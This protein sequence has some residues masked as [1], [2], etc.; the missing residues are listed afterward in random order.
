MMFQIKSRLPLNV[1]VVLQSDK[2]LKVAN[3]INTDIRHLK[4][5]FDVDIP[6]DQCKSLNHLV[7]DCGFIK[8]RN[9]SLKYQ[10]EVV[11]GLE[12]DK[13][14]RLSN[15]SGRITQA[16]QTY[17]LLD[18]HAQY[19]IAEKCLARGVR[20][21]HFS[22][23]FDD[24]CR[25]GIE[26]P[27]S[28]SSEASDFSGLSPPAISATFSIQQAT[29]LLLD[30][31]HAMARV[32]DVVPKKHPAA[33]EFCQ[34]LSQAI[35]HQNPEDVA[36]VKAA[37]SARSP[38][39]SYEA[40]L[41][42]NPNWISQRIR[43]TIPQ[44]DVLCARLVEVQET[45]SQPQFIVDDIKLLNDKVA[46]EF[47]K[48]LLHCRRG[49]LS[50][51][52]GIPLLF[53]VRTDSEGLA[54]YRHIRGNSRLESSHQKFNNVFHG[55]YNVSLQVASCIMVLHTHRSNI[56]ASKRNRKNFPKIGHYQILL[57]TT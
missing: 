14:L 34:A 1:K 10:V 21:M 44:P 50:D 13:S 55:S 38:P 17:C 40:V 26:S 9:T 29:G 27:N 5:D 42:A 54:V 25:P 12:L 18:V 51:I 30:A 7:H 46:S 15:W 33:R 2:F 47:D 31:T 48:L 6:P 8:R 11:L 28:E 39:H 49:C 22:E 4:E 23:H 43:R 3:Y 37:L 53:N 35:F 24:D 20:G 45:Y 41:A 57:S 19:M 32:T 16:G 36:K 56:D 52:P